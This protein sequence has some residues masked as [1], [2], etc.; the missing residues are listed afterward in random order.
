MRSF[1]TA[2]AYDSWIHLNRQLFWTNLS[3]FRFHIQAER[4][5]SLLKLVDERFPDSTIRYLSSSG[6]DEDYQT[7]Y[8][9]GIFPIN[10]LHILVFRQVFAIHTVYCQAIIDF[11]HLVVSSLDENELEL[12]N[13]TY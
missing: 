12:S 13:L 4:I 3:D 1:F 10:R 5:K 6:E 8:K 7:L 9:L 11:M 2:T